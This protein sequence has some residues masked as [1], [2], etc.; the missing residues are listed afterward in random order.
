MDGADYRFAAMQT[1]REAG[2]KADPDLARDYRNLAAAYLALARFR[3]RIEQHYA[4]TR[5]ARRP[6]RR[7][8][9]A[10]R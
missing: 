5:D 10:L 9:R 8:E 4:G 6:G 7:Q 1:W 3:D 2:Q